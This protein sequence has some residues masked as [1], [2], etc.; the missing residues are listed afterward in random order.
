MRLQYL[1]DKVQGLDPVHSNSKIFLPSEL[2][3]FGKQPLA[4]SFVTTRIPCA[5]VHTDGSGGL[6][7]D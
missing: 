5:G 7:V 1:T 3:V 2:E 4:L 6:L